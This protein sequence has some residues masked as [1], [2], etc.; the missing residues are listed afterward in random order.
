MVIQDEETV[1]RKE[2][3]NDQKT[4]N[5]EQNLLLG[6]S[7]PKVTQFDNT[8]SSEEQIFNFKI[9]MDYRL[10]QG[11]KGLNSFTCLPKY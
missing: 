10:F 4:V 9:S 5:G 3:K 1:L 11:V 2:D 6:C 7:T 8:I